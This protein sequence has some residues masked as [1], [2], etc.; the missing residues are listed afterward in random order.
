MTFTVRATWFTA[1]A[2]LSM[3]L[4]HSEAGAASFN[5]R[6]A[7]TPAENAICNDRRLSQTDERMAS[8]YFGL[9]N[10]LSYRRATQLKR[11]QKDWLMERDDCGY[12]KSCLRRAYRER[13]AVMCDIADDEGLNCDD[14]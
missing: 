5:C 4:V 8:I 6:Y 2:M 9:Q 13:I 7:K 1:I 12:S 14:Y 3:T 10:D 11:G